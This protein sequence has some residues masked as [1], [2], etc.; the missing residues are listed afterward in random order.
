MS[1]RLIALVL[2]SFL[3]VVA[4]LMV[5]GMLPQEA[6]SV[7]GET[8]RQKGAW[9]RTLRETTPLLIA[10]V[11]V[12][13]GL[14]A[15]LFNIGVE[16]QFLLGAATAAF[17]GLA[18]GGPIGVILAIVAGSIAGALWAWPAG[19]I[20]AYRGGHEVITTIML[21]NV[22]VFFTTWL[23]AGPLKAPNQQSTTTATL[24]PGTRLPSLYSS[25]P[26][27]LN[28]AMVLAI[29]LV[30]ALAIWLNRTVAGYELSATGANPSA[31]EVAGV[32][33][34][35]VT[36]RA[37]A[38]SGAIAGLAGACQVLAYEW[39]FYE[40]FSPGYGFD[41]LGVALL[42]GSTPWGLLPA[43]VLFGLLTTGSTALAANGVP[44]GLNGVL[45]GL[46]IIGFAAYRYRRKRA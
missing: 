40:G 17:V 19:W 10:G 28:L 4:A 37:M 39:R 14:R 23:V 44:R 27:F 5:A 41:A 16:G 15:G 21:N 36:V 45:L 32:D 42:A 7:L 13:L 3:L 30:V 34:K 8:F 26:F 25:P 1:A 46:L 9:A 33:V 18:A 38:A 29:L 6:L 20:K 11:A 31:A 35:R 12:F 22:A 43:S 2:M 24:P